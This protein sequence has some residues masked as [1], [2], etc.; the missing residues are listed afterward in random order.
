MKISNT[1]SK[2]III[3]TGVPQGTVLSPI[4]YLIY[5]SSLTNLNL[6]GKLFSCADD[7]AILI[8]GTHWE[9]VH[10]N[11]EVDMRLINTWFLKHKLRINYTKSKF[12]AFTQDKRTQSK[13]NKIKIHDLNCKINY[14]SCDIINKTEYTKYLG[15]I[16]DQHLKWDTHI[17]T[18]VMKL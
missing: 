12:I 10:H 18:I 1:L 5:V 9:E 13:F 16:I 11:A 8:T 3:T 15:I 2:E 7:T 4:L 14:C 6:Y 17:N